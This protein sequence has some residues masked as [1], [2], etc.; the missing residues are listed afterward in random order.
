MPLHVGKGRDISTA[1]ADIIDYVENPQKTDFGKFIYG[2]ECDTRLADAEFLLSKRQYANLTGRNQGADD[3]IAY[4]LRQ[5]F[6]PG[7]VTPEEANQIG[8]E[9]ALKLTKGNHAF[10]VCTHVDKHHVHN[11]IIIN[12]TTL[13][14][15]KKFR[16]FWGSTWAI[17]RMNDKLCL[18][19]GLSIIENPKPSREHYGTW[20]G[21]KKQPSF[22]E[23]I[24]I[25]I[26]AAL[27][28]KPKDF[29]ELLKKLEAAGIEVNRERKHLRFRVPGQE[30]YDTS[31]IVK[32]L[33]DRSMKADKRRNAFIII[34]IAF[35]V[36][37]MMVL[38]LY[39]LGTDRE[40]RLYLQG[41]YQGSF[42]NST[43]TVFEKLEHNNQIEAVGKEAAMG[44]SR[45]NDYTLDVYYR[46][47]NALELKG[48][49]DLLGKMPEAENEI[50]VEQSYLEHLGLPVQ[51]DQTVTLDMPFGKNQTYHVCGI[52]QSSNA[53]RIYQV[54]VSDGLYS[55][56]EKANCYDLLVRVKNTENM[57]SETLK[58]LINEI[59]EQSGVPEQY[60]MYSSTYFGL[61]EEKSTLELLVIIG[62][63]SLIVL[64]CSLVIY[65]LFYISV[66]G[67]T[68]EYGRLRVL[69]ATSV[70]IKRIVRKES[71]LLS[72]AAIPIG[73]VLGSVLGYC[74]VPDGWHWMTTLE[75]AVVI[76]LV[77]EI[78]LKIAVHTPVKKASMVSPIE[79]L[80]INTTDTPATEKT[81]IEHRKITPSSLARMSFARNK[82]K[83]ILT[84]L[85]L[86]FAGVLLMCAATYL[87]STDVESMA[88]QQFA[89]GDIVLSLDPAN[90]NAEDRPAGINALQT[91]NPLD[92]V[93]EETISDMDG[94][95]NIEFIQGC[96]SNMEFPTPFKDG[97]SH[98]FTQIGIPENQYEAFSQGLIEG[99][100]DRQKLINGKGVIV[101]NSA[102]LLS[103]YYNYTPQIGDIVKVETADGQWEEFTVMGIG[104]APNLG[105]DSASFY[106]PQELLPM[107]KENVSNFNITCIVDVERDQLTE[108]ENKIFQLAEN[109]GGIEVFSISDIITYLQEE[110][111]NIKMPLYGLVFFIAV[112]GLISLINTLMTNIISRQQEF[113]VLQSVGLSSKQF[114]KMLQTECF[115]YVSGTAIL[116]LTIG[117]LT[118]FVLCK[119]F[120]QVGTFGTLTY[121]FPVL[122]ISIYF[123]ALFFILAAY[124]VFSVRYSKRHPV[125]ERIKTM[126]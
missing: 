20:L 81:R 92:E 114:S 6:K 59:A 5:A 111:D 16:N 101:D 115:Y 71:F 26:D 125:I 77:T 106:F 51:L 72:C 53:S 61:A 32:K 7:E 14:C 52:I 95:K 123:V 10:V 27:E 124:S 63:S 19:H 24:R 119:V 78:A 62:A 68:H 33:A 99:T 110:M 76:A 55:R 122:E 100:A 21:N 9:L 42:I 67:K 60:V 25:V 75:C 120:N 15:Q 98:F 73:V 12:S 108:V 105:G 3:V 96:V 83:A 86:G 31:A 109:R 69:G 37:L 89:N 22:Q 94:V 113:G 79:A 118:G 112:F 45:I 2:Y 80:R 50:I 102:K 91:K 85:S 44:T 97:N 47:Q 88:K 29:E 126:E 64:A 18:E 103:D 13:D 28:E 49:T 48:V 4:H 65:S 66:I 40:N 70:Q 38:A 82:K 35:A 34:T 74:F 41:R 84:V 39:N 117:T 121:H 36:S 8:R 57:D 87:N 46:D 93:L 116:T 11:H 104:K 1:I 90:T 17:R 30:N 23:Q 58:L 43:S 54:I 56:Y 107:M